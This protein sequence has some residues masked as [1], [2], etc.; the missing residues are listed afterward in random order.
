M[1]RYTSLTL[2]TQASVVD[3]LLPNTLWCLGCCSR[4]QGFRGNTAW[5][6]AVQD[7]PKPGRTENPGQRPQGVCHGTRLHFRDVAP[8]LPRGMLGNGF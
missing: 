4:C 3:Q 8:G 2:T 6:P 1:T 7:R 5:A